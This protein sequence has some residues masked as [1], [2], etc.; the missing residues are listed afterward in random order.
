MHET[1]I[2]LLLMTMENK[3]TTDDRDEIER[4][5]ILIVS[6]EFFVIFIKV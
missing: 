1:I 4:Y 6:V 2:K 5:E 3:N